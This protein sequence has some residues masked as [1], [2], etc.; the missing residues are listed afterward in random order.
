MASL[1]DYLEDTGVI[2]PDVS[3]IKADVELEFLKIF[4]AEIDLSAS[5]PQGRLIES[6]TAERTAFLEINAENANQTNPNLATGVFLDA[7]GSRFDVARVGVSSTRVYAT[8]TGTSG[9]V[10]LADS[11]AKTDAGDLFYAENDITIPA[12]GSVEGYFLSS[13]EGAIAC[14]SNTLTTIVSGTSGWTSINNP[15]AAIIGTDK[16]SDVTYWARIKGSRASSF[17]F[18]ESIKSEVNAIE[19]V[20]SSFVYDNG[21][22]SAVWYPPGSVVGDGGVL[23]PAHSI[24]VLVDG[25]DDDEIAQVVFGIKDGGCGYTVIDDANGTTDQSTVVNVVDGAYSVEYPVTFNRPFDIDIDI[26]ITVR[27]GTYSGDDL[28]QAVKDAISKYALGEVAGVDG[29]IIAAD[30]SPFE[31]AAAVSQELPSIFVSDCKLALTGGTTTAAT[32]EI[33]AS[34]IARVDQGDITVTVV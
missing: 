25:G 1:Y 17:G 12:S 31:I 18:L 9:A 6:K 10:I 26:D 13:V 21:T 27:M 15:V 7:I 29:L 20:V 32:I 16:E 11:V 34:Q 3:T 28:E 22:T 5:T 30:A 8:V 33:K 24:L 2:V 19:N 23:I 4:G 14:A